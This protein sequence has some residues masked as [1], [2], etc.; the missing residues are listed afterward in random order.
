ML[1]YYMLL[2]IFVTFLPNCFAHSCNTCSN[3]P[4]LSGQALLFDYKMIHQ[5][6]YSYF[7]QFHASYLDSQRIDLPRGYSY[8]ILCPQNIS[9]NG[10]HIR[11]IVMILWK[12][13]CWNC[14]IICQFGK[15]SDNNE[16][17]FIA[18]GFYSISHRIH[19][20]KLHWFIGQFKVV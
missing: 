17:G 14:Y 3:M 7:I 15:P 11:D 2:W 18:I 1:N 20:Y 5:M 12:N 10:K 4:H 13:P 16:N 19:W 8:P 9:D 6:P